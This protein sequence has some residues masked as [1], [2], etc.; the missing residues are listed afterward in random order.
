MS[1]PEAGG[2]AGPL[3]THAAKLEGWPWGTGPAQA[4]SSVMA[5]VMFSSIANISSRII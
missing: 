3:S 1:T 5:V 2:G 4:L